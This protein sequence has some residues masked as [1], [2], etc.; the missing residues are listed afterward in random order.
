MFFVNGFSDIFRI[1]SI[2]SSI[3]IAKDYL[4]PLYWEQGEYRGKYGSYK[5]LHT[6]RS[7]KVRGQRRQIAMG[8]VKRRNILYWPELPR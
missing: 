7:S 6:G 2:S 8:L 3:K 4:V 1:T 5:S